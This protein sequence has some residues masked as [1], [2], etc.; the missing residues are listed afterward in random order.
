MVLDCIHSEVDTLLRMNAD[1][2]GTTVKLINS[3]GKARKSKASF[4]QGLHQ[5]ICFPAVVPDPQ[6]LAFFS[7]GAERTL[8]CS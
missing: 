4:T 6:T 2:L 8:H 5:I 1:L 3:Q 7:G